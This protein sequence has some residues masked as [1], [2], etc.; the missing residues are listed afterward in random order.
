MIPAARLAATTL[1]LAVIGVAPAFA[2]RTV[3]DLYQQCKARDGNCYGYLLGIAD[4]LG[5]NSEAAKWVV[6]AKPSRAESYL[7][8]ARLCGGNYTSAA[9]ALAF[10]NWV[11]KHP[12]RRGDDMGIGA[13]DALIATWPCR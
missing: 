5:V 1:A 12:E 4:T 13:S 3:Q 6:G 9:L 8:G 7:L 2:A 11:E 10:T